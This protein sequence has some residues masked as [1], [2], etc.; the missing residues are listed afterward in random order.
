[1]YELYLTHVVCAGLSITGF[2]LRG[3][4]MATGSDL[5]HRRAVKIAPHVVDTL[6]LGSALAMLYRLPITLVDSPWLIAKL[7]ALLFYI[8]LGLVALRLGKSR[9]QRITAWLMALVVAAYIVVVALSK[10]AWGPLCPLAC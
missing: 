7:I 2:A 1:V 3:Y 6:L 9:A 5:L 8:T 4:W 10:S